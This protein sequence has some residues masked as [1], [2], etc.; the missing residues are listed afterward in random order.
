MAELEYCYP[1]DT[2]W[3]GCYPQDKLDAL[4]ESVKTFVE[5]L[6]WMTLRTLTAYRLATCPVK[7]RPASAGCL[8]IPTWVEAPVATGRMSNGSYIPVPFRSAPFI[9]IA[10]GGSWYNI[11]CACESG[12]S[13]Q[14]VP[15]IVLPSNAGGIDYIK[16]GADTL[17]RTAYRIDNGNLLVR[18]DGEKW[19]LRPDLLAA[20]G[21][22][23]RS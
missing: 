19:P 2:D 7:L 6:A 21:T 22:E 12:C 10:V 15:T 16:I 5:G 14:F 11:T 1:S 23:V 8:G 20:E 4:D 9:P 13:C 17:P 18:T 3:E